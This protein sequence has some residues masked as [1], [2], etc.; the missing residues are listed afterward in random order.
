LI[1][2]SVVR[3]TDDVSPAQSVAGGLAAAKLLRL[4]EAP[5]LSLAHLSAADRPDLS[6]SHRTASSLRAKKGGRRPAR[7]SDRAHEGRAEH[8]AARRDRCQVPPAAILHDGRPGQRLHRCR[9]PLGQLPAA[10]WLI[11]NRGYDAD[12]FRDASKDKGIHPCITGRKSRGK[13]V[14]YGRRL[15]QRRNRIEITFGRLKDWR[16]I[17][18]RYDRCPKVFLSAVALAATVMFWP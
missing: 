3:S 14:R 2:P 10:E 4:A 12:W 5:T 11:A 6:E 18:T 8:E 7:A 9:S 13:I 17:A 16:R 15:Y 1:F